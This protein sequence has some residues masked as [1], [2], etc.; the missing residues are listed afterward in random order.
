MYKHIL[1][2]SSILLSGCI[3][4]PHKHVSTPG[5]NVTIHDSDVQK[6]FLSSG[7]SIDGFSCDLAPELNKSPEGLF[8]SNPEYSWIDG[9]MLVPAYCAIT[10]YICVLAE[11]GEHREWKGNIGVFCNKSPD[12]MKFECSTYDGEFTCASKT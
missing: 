1:I 11:T 4:Y 7:S 9:R 8:F 10:V 12:L 3:V 5:F 6:A 2:F